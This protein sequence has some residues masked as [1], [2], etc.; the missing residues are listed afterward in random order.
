M[1]RLF[2]LVPKPV[3]VERDQLVLQN[4]IDDATTFARTFHSLAG[5]SG[6]RTKKEFANLA[7]SVLLTMAHKKQKRLNLL[8]FWWGD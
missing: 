8:R 7:E 2:G 3:N 5:T 6:S 4:D 1:L